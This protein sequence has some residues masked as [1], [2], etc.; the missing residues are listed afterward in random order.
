M[1]TA[2]RLTRMYG[3]FYAVRDVSFSIPAG[4]VAAFVGPNGAGKS[5]TM[6]MLTGLLAPTSGAARIAGL[7]IRHDRIAAVERLG[8]LPENGPLYDDM[9]P[10]ALLRFFGSA[11]GLTGKKLNE[12]IDAVIAQCRLEEVI[13]KPCGKLS[14]G[15]RQRA[16]LAQALLH[17]P[18]AL[19]LDE[20]TAGLDPNQIEQVRELLRE[21]G[22][23]KTI[24]LSTHI[25]SEVRAIAQ[26]VLFIH[27]GRLVHDGDTASL[28][29]NEEAMERR[30]KELSRSVSCDAGGDSE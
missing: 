7:D 24:L 23:S 25:L 1:I 3:R 30:F 26:R 22:Q 16:G 20:P 6:L 29:E 8:F 27:Q 4:Q 18:D 11:R 17:D 14:K 10:R 5:T 9:N 15:Y 13:G 28:G 12:R 2:D 19:I 21:L